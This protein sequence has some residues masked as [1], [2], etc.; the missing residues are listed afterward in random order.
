MRSMSALGEIPELVQIGLVASHN[1]QEGVLRHGRKR[2]DGINF[3]EQLN[4]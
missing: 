3:R 2:D 1:Y 4:S